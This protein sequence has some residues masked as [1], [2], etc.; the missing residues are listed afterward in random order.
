[1]KRRGRDP[2]APREGIVEDDR[3][4]KHIGGALKRG[5]TGERL[6]VSFLTVSGAALKFAHRPNT[7][8]ARMRPY[9][10]QTRPRGSMAPSVS[11]D[12]PSRLRTQVHATR[13]TATIPPTTT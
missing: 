9:T 1:M 13:A 11:M 10:T 7:T 12:S 8:S 6:A 3:E 5:A 4:E 2:D